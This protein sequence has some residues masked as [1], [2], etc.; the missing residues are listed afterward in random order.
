MLTCRPGCNA[1][2]DG[3]VCLLIDVKRVPSGLMKIAS[4]KMAIGEER[5]AHIEK[6]LMSAG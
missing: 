4:R 1:V 6:C 3:H 2:A 5:E